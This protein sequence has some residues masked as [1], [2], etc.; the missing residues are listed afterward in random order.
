MIYRAPFLAR[1]KRLSPQISPNQPP[2][3]ISQPNISP[4]TMTA[5]DVAFLPSLSLC[6]D[7][8][9][10]SPFNLQ[11]RTIQGTQQP[12]RP[13]VWNHPTHHTASRLEKQE[14]V[15]ET[16]LTRRELFKLHSNNST[17]DERFVCPKAG[18]GS[19]QQSS[20]VPNFG[21]IMRREMNVCDCRRSGSERRTTRATDSRRIRELFLQIEEDRATAKHESYETEMGWR[22]WC[23]LQDSNGSRMRCRGQTHCRIGRRWRV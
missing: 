17:N 14:A 22:T 12:R 8:Q 5:P 16:E 20:H 1:I 11:G 23:W 19:P 10:L 7:V 9:F 2:L 21:G 13:R 3:H 18:R 4:S 15:A 6:F